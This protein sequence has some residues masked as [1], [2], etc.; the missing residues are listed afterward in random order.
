M[1]RNDTITVQNITHVE[2]EKQ[3]YLTLLK[4]S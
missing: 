1:I 4:H 2:Y 3:N